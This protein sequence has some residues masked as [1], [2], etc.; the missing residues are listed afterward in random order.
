MICNQL[1][2]NP[3]VGNQYRS[4]GRK[5]IA[6]IEFGTL[7]NF[8]IVIPEAQRIVDEQ[9]V[10]EIV[11]Y[12]DQYYKSS[13]TGEF[14]F[15]G[16]ISIH[17]CAEDNNNYLVDGQHR[18]AAVLMAVLFSGNTFSFTLVIQKQTCDG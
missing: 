16:L 11:E 18:F 17:C 7:L 14:N 6:S 15:L 9:V 4:S 5:T 10:N 8:N 1:L 2:S 12:Q 3:G 13:R